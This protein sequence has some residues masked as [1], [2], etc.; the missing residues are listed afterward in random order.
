MYTHFVKT[1]KMTLER[2]M[3]LLVYNP[4][5]RFGLP[6]LDGFSVWD[7]EKDYEIDPEKFLS[8]G[9][10]TP[11]AGHRVFGKNL[12]TVYGGKVVYKAEQ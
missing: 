11:F 8:M 7:L 6:E 4:R 12:L 10:A 3:D 2:L 9:K 1:G 5:A